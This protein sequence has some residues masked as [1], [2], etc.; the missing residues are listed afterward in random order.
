MTR[1]V[2]FCPTCFASR[3]VEAAGEYERLTWRHVCGQ[4]WWLHERSGIAL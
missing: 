3:E 2:L 4:G 1:V